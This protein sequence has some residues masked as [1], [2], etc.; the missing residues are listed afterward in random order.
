MAKQPPSRN[1]KFLAVQRRILDVAQMLED[2]DRPGF[3]RD[4]MD[5]IGEL[6]RAY[7]SIDGLRGE[8]SQEER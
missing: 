2:K 7:W 1:S 5:A 6:Y 3:S 4:N 8:E